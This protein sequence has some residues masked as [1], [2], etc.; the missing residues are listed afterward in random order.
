MIG[1]RKL[2]VSVMPRPGEVLESWLG[3][4]ATRLDL[5]FGNLLREIGSSSD[6][7]DLRR[8]GI[9]VYL[10]E[11]ELAALAVSTGAAPDQLRAM[12]LAHY[13]GHVVSIDRSGSRL[14]WSTWRPRRTRFCPACLMDSGGRWQLWWRLPWVFVCD[15]HGCLLEDMCSLCGQEQLVT[16]FWPSRKLIPDLQRC[17]LWVGGEGQRTLCE[18]ELYTNACAP[19]AVNDPLAQAHSRL[20][21]ILAQKATTFGVYALSPVSGLRVL[22][23]LRVLSAR[24]IAAVAL[25]DVD[26]FLGA[27]RW[28][29]LKAR[30]A[31]SSASLGRRW[32]NP[33]AFSARAP[34]LITGIGIALALKILEAESVY[35]AGIRLRTILGWRLTQ[36]DRRSTPAILGGGHLSAALEAVNLSAVSVHLHPSNKL[37]YRT[38][39]E[40][41][42]Y[43]GGDDAGRFDAALRSTPTTLWREWAVRFFPTSYPYLDGASTSLSALLLIVGTRI[44]VDDAY[45]RLGWEGRRLGRIAVLDYLSGNPLWPN[46][47]TAIV[48]LHDYLLSDPSP[49]DYQRRRALDYSDLLPA[50]QW[51]NICQRVNLS[52]VDSDTFLQIARAWLFERVSGRP[53]A[54]CPFLSG[55]AGSQPERDQFVE[56]FTSELVR[57]L[58][59]EAERF[60]HA[61]S[62]VDEP[63]WWVAPLNIVSDLDLPGPDPGTISI[64]ELHQVMDAKAINVPEA[65]R[66]FGVGTSLIRLLL[67]RYPEEGKA[68]QERRARLPTQLERLT[69]SL[70]RQ[71][72][73]RLHHGEGLSIRFIAAQFGV[74]SNEVIAL[75]SEYNVDTRKGVARPRTDIDPAWF[76]RE[77]VENGRSQRDLADQ[78]G[79]SRTALRAFALQ[80]GI[81]VAR[82]P[83]RRRRRGYQPTL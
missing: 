63:V 71:E 11:R 28:C 21:E 39:T 18:N 81:P 25:D 20:S 66:H 17:S 57:A 26:D 67:E 27:N 2:P 9:S 34:A 47:A 45:R 37:R 1:R 13:D 23:D 53:A 31:A 42:R 33:S 83:R 82:Y 3:T 74:R 4:L 46:I 79:A 64:P 51:T 55:N 62:I 77:C 50:D 58:D 60:L 54:T 40:F 12:T 16:P 7:V 8:K 19:L 36:D 5:P 48:R 14:Y 38:I 73:I 80:H 59:R 22:A 10:T 69:S 44:S 32:G 52:Q 65:A 15:T 61:H 76:R 43:P 41:P 72:L 70:T 29:S 30:V 56:R 35:E 75:A 24:L 78:T 68:R 6:G 49:I